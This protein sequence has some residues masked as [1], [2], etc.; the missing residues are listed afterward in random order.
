[1]NTGNR[2]SK[3]NHCYISIMNIIQGEVDPTQ[4]HK[5]LQRI[6]E[7]KLANFIPWSPASLRVVLTRKSP[8]TESK[9]RVSGLMLANHTS[10]STLFH[11]AAVDF[12]KMKKRNAYIDQFKKADMFKDNFDEYRMAT[13]PEYL[14][15]CYSKQDQ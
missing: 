7:R 2:E 3:L 14:N 6:R 4:V 8:Y 15:Y 5:S 9:N 13:K 12:D 11:R 1:M 10:V